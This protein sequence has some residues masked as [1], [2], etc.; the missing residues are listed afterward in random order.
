MHQELEELK[1][2]LTYSIS[3]NSITELDRKHAKELDS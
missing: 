2:E 3:H 1:G